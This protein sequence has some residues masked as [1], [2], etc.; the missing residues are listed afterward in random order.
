MKPQSKRLLFLA[1]LVVFLAVAARPVPPQPNY[2]IVVLTDLPATMNVG[3][4][5]TMEIL[6]TSDI[7]FINAI[8]MPAEFFPGRY[9]VSQGG[10]DLARAGTS[11]HL[12]ITFTAK[13]PTAELPNGVAP[14]SVSVGVR[15]PGG[16]VVSE[17]FDR[18]IA[19]P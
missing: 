4:S 13:D 17:R 5:Y 19:V 18:Y 10:G 12:Y 6:V 16:V 15:Y 8:A 2:Q 9:V 1:V 14:I 11:A 7:A 3:E